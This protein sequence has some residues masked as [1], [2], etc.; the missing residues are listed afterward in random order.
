MTT[1]LVSVTSGTSLLSTVSSTTTVTKDTTAQTATITG[2]AAYA[3]SGLSTTVNLVQL[4]NT[5]YVKTTSSF[6]LYL[7]AIVSGTTYNIAQITSGITV[8]SSILSTG[9]V[10]GFVLTPASTVI[11]D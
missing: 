5:P 6:S 2:C 3:E 4:L 11:S 8:P 1:A 10:T 9:T 7:Y